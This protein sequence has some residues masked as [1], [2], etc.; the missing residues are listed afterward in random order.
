MQDD[1][2][3]ALLREIRDL[4]A[5]REAQYTNHLANTEKAYAEQLKRS[6][7]QALRWA[8]IHWVALFFITFFAVYLALAAAN[9]T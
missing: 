6:R 7:Q 2:A 5:A 1:Q 8:F 4:L 9:Q 3:N